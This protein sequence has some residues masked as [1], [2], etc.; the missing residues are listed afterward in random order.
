MTVSAG[1]RRRS[2]FLL[3]LGT[4]AIVLAFVIGPAASAA[5]AQE[6]DSCAIEQFVT[7]D[8]VDL[9]AYAAC[10]EAQNQAAGGLA[11]TGGNNLGYVGLGAGLIALGGAFMWTSHRQRQRTA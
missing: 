7:G 5:S 4:V 2:P 3:L 1:V 8:Q 10:V 11:R 9:V 6:A